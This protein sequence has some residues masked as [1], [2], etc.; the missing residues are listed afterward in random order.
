VLFENSERELKCIYGWQPLR[1]G[2]IIDHPDSKIDN[3]NNPI[4][5]M[6]V[7]NEFTT[8]NFFRWVR[9]STNGQRVGDEIW[10]ICHLVSYEDR[11]YYYHIFVALD[12][13][14]MELKRYSRIF[15]FE[16]EKVEYTLGFVYLEESRELLIGYSLMDRE[17]KYMTISRDKVEELFLS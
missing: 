8:P 9:G 7:T 10:F 16:K 1:I 2:N 12:A 11:R 15:T 14:T 13:K 17:T 5:K 4:R 3:K 6:V